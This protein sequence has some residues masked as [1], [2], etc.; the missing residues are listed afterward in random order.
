MSSQRNRQ[1]IKNSD[2]KEIIKHPGDIGYNFDTA[3]H[4]NWKIDRENNKWKEN[5]FLIAMLIIPTIVINLSYLFTQDMILSQMIYQINLV[6]L[7]LFFK[8][9]V[10]IDMKIDILYIKPLKR[11]QKQKKF[12]FLCIPWVIF[13]ILILPMILKYFEYDIFGNIKFLM[14]SGLIK[15]SLIQERIHIFYFLVLFLEFGFI[16]PII[17]FRHY[18]ILIHSRYNE[19]FF[20]SAFIYIILLLNHFY[21]LFFYFSLDWKIGLIFLVGFCLN[22]YIVIL[23]K[24]RIGIIYAYIHQ[25]CMNLGIFLFIF[26]CNGFSFIINNNDGHLKYYSKRNY[27]DFVLDLFVDNIDLEIEN[28]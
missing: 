26:F 18:F 24:I 4:D 14:P 9:F 12:G 17:E 23:R 20:I 10:E 2:D 28:N 6:S 5:G 3:K 16:L 19:T 25:I 21:V 15:G 11:I 22:Y 1:N 8:K 7:F 13:F 27:F